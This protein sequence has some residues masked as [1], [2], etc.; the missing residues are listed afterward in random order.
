ME[1][2]FN[3]LGKYESESEEKEKKFRTDIEELKLPL[4]N[5]LDESKLI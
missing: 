2:V 4:V 5:G 3:V 1:E